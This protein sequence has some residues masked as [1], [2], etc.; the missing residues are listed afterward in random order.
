ML[1]RHLSVVMWLLLCPLP[2]PASTMECCLDSCSPICRPCGRYIFETYGM[3]IFILVA[4]AEASADSDYLSLKK[5]WEL[6]KKHSFFAHFNHTISGPSIW[7][8]HGDS[9]PAS[10]PSSR[11]PPA[12]QPLPAWACTAPTTWAAA[13][14]AGPAGVCPPTSGHATATGEQQG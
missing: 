2:W 11:T 14:L 10:G 7:A 13:V 4:Q 3:L 1:L 12:A 8:A 6:Q 9:T 5:R